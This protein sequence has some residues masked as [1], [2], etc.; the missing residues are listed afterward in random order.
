DWEA[1]LHVGVSRYQAILVS[2]PFL[3]FGPISLFLFFSILFGRQTRHGYRY[4]YGILFLLF[5]FV[6]AS[7]GATLEKSRFDE[8]AERFFFGALPKSDVWRQTILPSAEKEWTQPENGLLGGNVTAV[9]Q[10]ESTFDMEDLKQKEWKV[11]FQ[12]ADI[13]RSVDLKPKTQVNIIG[14]QKDE[15]HFQATIIRRPKTA[16]KQDSQEMDEKD[17]SESSRSDKEDGAEKEEHDSDE[18]ESD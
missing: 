5:L 8:P 6:S 17:D 14:N 1:F 12:N 18:S 16:H 15:D 7:L 11:N 2:L 3:W 10:A 13:D 9:D 4:T